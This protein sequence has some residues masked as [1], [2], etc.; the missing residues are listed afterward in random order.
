MTDT[1]SGYARLAQAVYGR[2]KKHKNKDESVEAE[3]LRKKKMRWES[4]LT[5]TPERGTK[6][7]RKLKRRRKLPPEMKKDCEELL[8]RL[9]KAADSSAKVQRRRRMWR[10]ESPPPDFV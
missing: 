8:S 7:R 10:W 3:R 9:N 2:T 6:G 4:V 1:R 5:I